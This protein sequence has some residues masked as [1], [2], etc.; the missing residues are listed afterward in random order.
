MQAQVQ[1]GAQR[2]PG[3]RH[4]VVE[5]LDLGQDRAIERVDVRPVELN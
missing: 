5:L 3:L 2:L 4:P 1:G